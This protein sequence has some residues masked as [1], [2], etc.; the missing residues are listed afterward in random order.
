MIS[1]VKLGHFIS[2]KY[3]EEAEKKIREVRIRN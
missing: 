1:V 2:K 3:Q